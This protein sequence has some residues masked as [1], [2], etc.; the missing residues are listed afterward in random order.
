[1]VIKFL[2]T[3]SSRAIP[4]ANCKCGQ[5]RSKDKKDKRLR[6]SILINDEILIDVG[7]DFL[8]QKKKYKIILDKIKMIFLT[9]LHEDAA[10]GLENIYLL[11][12]KTFVQRPEIFKT[13]VGR[14]KIKSFKV[15]HAKD[16]ETF[17]FL[18]EENRPRRS[19]AYI[20]D[21][22]RI[23]VKVKKILSAAD[24]II[25]DGSVLNRDFGGHL[26][27]E[28]SLPLLK[29]FKAKI[30]FTHNGHTRLPHAQL[31]KLIQKKGGG[32]FRLAHDG[33]KISI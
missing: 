19:V 33:M 9:H 18:I 16:I 7:P 6:S 24:I 25:F 12:P 32:N 14:I 23:T 4:R 30:Y 13:E 11:S 8:I 31:E 5:C 28:K 2:G 26:A 15:P 27:I 3:S 21:I 10:A 22:S 20:S 17:G 29:K 1:M